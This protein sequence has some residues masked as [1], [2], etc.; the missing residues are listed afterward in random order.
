M[1]NK[2]IIHLGT[3]LGL[4]FNEKDNFPDL[5][6]KNYVVFNGANAQRCGINGNHTDDEILQEFGVHLR[7]MGHIEKCLEIQQV[8][9]IHHG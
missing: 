4:K 3:T 1:T 9:S 2:E 6:I 5:L 7:T 8:L